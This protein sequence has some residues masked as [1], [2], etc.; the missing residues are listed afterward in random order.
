MNIVKYRISRLI[1]TL[2]PITLM[3]GLS[4]SNTIVAETTKNPAFPEKIMLRLSSYAVNQVSTDITVL[5]SAGVG[6]IFSFDEELGGE[7]SAT[8][9]RF[10]AY[11]RFNE[12]HRIDFSS[13][14]IDR[15][16][17]KTLIG[18]GIT[19]GDELFLVNET[20]ISELN[21]SLSKIA[22]A[23][24][25]Y[26]SPSVEMSFTAGLNITDYEFNYSLEDGNRASVNGASAP[27]PMFGL[28]MGYAINKNWSVNY[29]TESFFI[30]IENEFKGTFLNYEL[31]IEYKFDNKLAI[32][33]GLVRSSLDL[34]VEDS[35]WNGSI[36]DSYRGMLLYAA[37]Y[38]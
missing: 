13:F 11:Y 33:A 24:S 3:S 30:E 26:H 22:Y 16:G 8:I 9:P 6:T 4:T 7:D 29:I 2:L 17:L 14:R 36:V 28:R 15:D 1:L 37:Y 35:D 18:T 27:L 21:Y 38:F 12:R 34:E 31:D 10:D 32:G 25:F 20:V 23:Y 19:I 5:S